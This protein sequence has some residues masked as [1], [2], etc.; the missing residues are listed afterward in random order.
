M[1]AALFNPDDAIAR[2]PWL[3]AALILAAYL[4]ACCL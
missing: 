1:M 2:R 3:C 4:I